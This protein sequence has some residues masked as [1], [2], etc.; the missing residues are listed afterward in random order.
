MVLMLHAPDEARIARYTGAGAMV[1][2][3]WKL[4]AFP[5]VA[6]SLGRAIF[7]ERRA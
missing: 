6:A 7:S 3:V 5:A 1:V 2:P 4:D